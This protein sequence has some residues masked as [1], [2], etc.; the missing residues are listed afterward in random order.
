[1]PDLIVLAFVTFGPLYQLFNLVYKY[2]VSIRSFRELVILV[3]V[4]LVTT[5]LF[6]SYIVVDKGHPAVYYLLVFSIGGIVV[7]LVTKSYPSTGALCHVVSVAYFA[8]VDGLSNLFFWP[9]IA[10][11][12][13]ASSAFLGSVWKKRKEVYISRSKSS[14]KTTEEEWSLLDGGW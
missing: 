1:M 3:A 14:F 4:T 8:L 7:D 13:L 12:V 9:A 11:L 2:Q 5:T 10:I 6:F